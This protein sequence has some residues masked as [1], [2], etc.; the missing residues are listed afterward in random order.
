MNGRP[1]ICTTRG[2]CQ[3]DSNRLWFMLK[4][5]AAYAVIEL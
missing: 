3:K 2:R 1:P 4:L 5:P